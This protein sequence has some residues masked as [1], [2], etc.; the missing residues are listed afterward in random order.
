MTLVL[1][2]LHR[3]FAGV[4]AVDGVTLAV[5]RGRALA[6]IGPNGAGKTSVVNLASGAERP[7]SGRVTVDDRDLTGAGPRQFA[8]AGV[9]R[10]FQG[11]RL[12]ES[13]TV[14]ENV[15]VGGHG[16]ARQPLLGAVLRSPGFRRRERALREGAV[17][18]L[19]A[20]GMAWAATRPV[21]ALSHGQRRRVELARALAARPSY[22][23][24]DEPGAGLDPE[25]VRALAATLRRLAGTGL[26]LL[27]VEHD[28]ALVEQVCDGCVALVAGRVAAAGSF[29]QVSRQAD[30]A[31]Q[32]GA[33]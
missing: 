22:L 31:A 5:E 28:A 11:L 2:D 15:L 16:A 10:T 14:Q 18:A 1:S 21:T 25:A 27:L 23:V 30:I 29:A 13:M 8:R 17:T 9:V 3:S 32:L 19:D 24:L 33:G 26:G 12:F 4:R 20:V 7:D 6:L